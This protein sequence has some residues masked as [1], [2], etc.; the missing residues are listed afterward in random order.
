MKVGET[1][2]NILEVFFNVVFGNC[3]DLTFV[4]E[5]SFFSVFQNHVSNFLLIV[6]VDVDEADDFAVTEFVV[7]Q[8]FVFGYFMNLV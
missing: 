5:R 8:N 4:V 6:Q 7:H 1:L 2:A 3:P